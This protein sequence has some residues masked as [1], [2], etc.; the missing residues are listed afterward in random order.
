[1][2][3]ACC[4]IKIESRRKGSAA[5][6]PVVRGSSADC[7]QERAVVVA[8]NGVWKRGCGYDGSMVTLNQQEAVC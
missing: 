6:R 1:M 4:T 3:L 5:Y 7:C 8:L 2:N